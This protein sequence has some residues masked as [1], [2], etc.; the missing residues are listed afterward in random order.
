MWRHPL[1][2]CEKISRPQGPRVNSAARDGGVSTS[3]GR[4]VRRTGTIKSPAPSDLRSKSSDLP[5][6]RGRAHKL[7][8]LRS[9]FHGFS[10]ATCK[11]L[12]ADLIADK[13]PNLD[14]LPDLLNIRSNEIFDRDIRILDEGLFQETHLGIKLR[15]TPFDDPFQEIFRFSLSASLLLVNLAFSGQKFFR[16]V[17]S[18]NKMRIAG[19]YV[20]GDVL[21]QILKLRV[22]RHEIGFTIDLD[23]RT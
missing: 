8:P 13:S 4:R 2:N 7:S 20:H 16:H 21:D 18:A 6:P 3:Y 19:R 23:H 1:R 14:V 9:F 17:L 5:R 12:F 10:V 22:S 11:N 15:H